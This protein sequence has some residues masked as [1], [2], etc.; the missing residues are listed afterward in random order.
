MPV[1]Q[2]EL[3]AQH[4]RRRYVDCYVLVSVSDQKQTMLTS[5]MSCWRVAASDGLIEQA[6]TLSGAPLFPLLGEK[7]FIFPLAGEC[8]LWYYVREWTN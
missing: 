8:G 3:A 7:I 5:G 6:S 4:D 1:E 2:E